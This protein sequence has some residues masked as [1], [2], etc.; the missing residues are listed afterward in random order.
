[1]KVRKEVPM[2]YL[3]LLTFGSSD[4]TFIFFSSV[5]NILSFLFLAIICLVSCLPILEESRYNRC[6]IRLYRKHAKISSLEPD[7]KKKKKRSL[8]T[9]RDF[10]QF[11]DLSNSP[12]YSNLMDF[13]SSESVW[14]AVC[15]GIQNSNYLFNSILYF[16]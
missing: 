11:L 7:R 9:G 14:N 13:S 12:W 5:P 4:P 8:G 1:M 15:K 6:C 2:N 3:D 10:Q 16:P